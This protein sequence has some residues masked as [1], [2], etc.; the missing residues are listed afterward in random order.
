MPTKTVLQ[1]TGAACGFAVPI[2]AFGCIATAIAS[3]PEFSWTNNALSDLGVVSGIT[4][5][6]F[7]VGLFTAGLLGFLFAVLGLFSF[8]KGSTVGKAGAIVFALATVWLMAIGIFNEDFR[9]THFIVSV[10]FFATLPIALWVLTAGL[11]LKRMVKLAVFTLTASFVAAAP[12]ILYYT[13]H[14]VPNVAIPETISGLTG[15]IWAIIISYK[16]L[17]TKVT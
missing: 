1:K 7:N 14:Y 13:I 3:Y 4:G 8:F 5:P 10:L 9:P 2:V 16:I 12:W 15:A 11:Y 6:V 17:Q